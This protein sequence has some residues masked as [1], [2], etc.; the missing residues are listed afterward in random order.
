[1]YVLTIKINLKN[2]RRL[3]MRNKKTI[4]ILIVAICCS[5]IAGIGIY[6][7]LLPQK[8]TI[9]VY[10][11]DYEAGTLLTSEMLTSMQVDSQIIV[12]G[13]SQATDSYYIT[14]ATINH[15]LKQGNTIKTN[16]SKGT[17]VI[18]QQLS[19]TG[20]N[21]LEHAMKSDS[22]AVTVPVNA[23]T[24]ITNDLKAGS[25]VNVYTS[26]TSNNGL[27]ETTLLFQNMKVLAIYKT[28]DGVLTGVS[29]EV[30]Q[31]ESLK[32]IY[33]TTYETVYLGLVNENGYQVTDN[34]LTYAK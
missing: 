8:T 28:N 19:V 32:L 31:S 13:A 17:S 25:R 30:D 23:T 2:E 33:A 16:V 14:S 15:V 12:N 27:P 20:G 4:I 7:Y 24:G 29:L 5:I 9:Y 18:P 21:A 10:K 26:Q 34:G 3:F 11:Q 6:S 1:M 22:I